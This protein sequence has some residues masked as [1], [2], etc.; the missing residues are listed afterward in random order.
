MGVKQLEKQRATG[1]CTWNCPEV[2]PDA[3]AVV[4]VRMVEHAHHQ[5][6][7]HRHAANLCRNRDKPR[8]GSEGDE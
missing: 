1:K 3:K 8:E 5:R 6:M 7:G 4:L 2:E